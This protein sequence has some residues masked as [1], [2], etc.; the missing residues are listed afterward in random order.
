MKNVAIMITC[1]FMLMSFFGSSFLVADID[2]GYFDFVSESK[3]FVVYSDIPHKFNYYILVAAETIFQKLSETFLIKEEDTLPDKSVII[4]F[5]NLHSFAISKITDKNLL[6]TDGKTINKAELES[7]VGN[8]LYKQ[9]PNDVYGFNVATTF[10]GND[11]NV[12]FYIPNISI[13]PYEEIYDYAPFFQAVTE[14]F[15]RNYLGNDL[16]EWF[17]RGILSA[18]G[19]YKKEFEFSMFYRI[20]EYECFTYEREFWSDVVLL[21]DYGKSSGITLEGILNDTS[22]KTDPLYESYVSLFAHYLFFDTIR[23]SISRINIVNKLKKTILS[24]G[25]L[26][27]EDLKVIIKE[28]NNNDLA[29][30]EDEFYSFYSSN[31]DDWRIQQFWRV[32]NSSSGINANIYTTEKIEKKAD[33]PN[34]KLAIDGDKNTAYETELPFK[35]G[36]AFIIDAEA[37]LQSKVAF[38]H[39]AN[40]GIN[41]SKT[42][43]GYLPKKARVISSYDGKNW[44]VW[45]YINSNIPIVYIRKNYHINYRYWGIV[46]DLDMETPITI[47]E[48]K[49][50]F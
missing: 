40:L 3:H 47:N 45:G 46:T 15:I 26:T 42:G 24:N 9:S 27:N 12:V 36:E 19:D 31:S 16:P 33:I 50:R 35:K 38:I 18:A 41:G 11:A 34:F 37:Y 7:L 5:E 48:M 20:E 32:Y 13:A 2:V 21:S 29:K 22:D 14:Q 8:R 39:F 43:N 1:F 25:N 44:V 23:S 28:E 30:L 10:N 4:I 17:V 6:E 49:T